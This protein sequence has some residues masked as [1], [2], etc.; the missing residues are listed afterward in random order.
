M[1]LPPGPPSARDRRRKGLLISVARGTD[2]PSV[3]LF[4]GPRVQRRVSGPVRLSPLQLALVSVVYGHAPASVSRTKVSRL[5][6]ASDD[7][8][9]RHRLRQLLVE[10]RAK[11]DGLIEADGDELRTSSG[12]V[13]DLAHFERALEDETL[14]TAAAIARRGFAPISLSGVDDSYDDW[15][16]QVHAGLLRRLRGRASATWT[17]AIETG[18]WASARDAA[19]ATYSLDPRSSEAIARVIEA[20]GRVGDEEEA[21]RAYALYLESGD[22]SGDRSRSVDEVM[23]RV[24]QALRTPVIKAAPPTSPLIGRQDALASARSLFEH[25]DQGRF[26]VTLITGESGI[27]K[28]RLLRELQ[29]EA[30]FRGLRCLG[31]QAVELEARIPLNP[32][33]D[34]LRGVD[35]VPHLN[36]L[37]APWNAVIGAVL[38]PGTLPEPAGEL[39]PIQERALPRRLLDAFSL[40]L[41]RLAN[42]QPTILFLDDLHWADT[43]TI[44][45]L[46][47]IQ[48]RWAGGPFGVMAT[49]RTDLVR[50]EE[51]VA[52]YLFQTDDLLTSRV[53]LR[54][55]SMDEGIQLVRQL[56][57]G[58][59]DDEQCRRICALAGLHP[60]CIAELTRDFVTGHFALTSDAMDELLIPVSLEQIV[61]ERLEQLD[62]VARRVAGFLA[63]GARPMRLQTLAALAAISLE[64]AADA[65]D[66]LRRARLVESEHGRSRVVHELFRSAIYRDLGE[67]RRTLHH[68]AFADQVQAEGEESAGELAIHYDR[69]GARESAARYGWIAADRAMETGTV[70]EAGHFYQLVSDNE[71]DPVRRAEALSGQARALHLARDITRAN[72]MLELAA[73]QLRAVGKAAE[74]LRLDIKRIEGLAETGA[75][76]LI[77]L[78]DRLAELKRHASDH[79]DWEA[80]ALGLDVELHLLHRAGDVVGIR[81]VFDEMRA[82]ADKGC[83]QATILAHAGLAMGVLFADPTDALASAQLAAELSAASGHHRLK[84]L[85]R[86]MVVLQYRGTLQ[87]PE[88]EAII[89]EARS[90]AERSGDVLLRFSIESNVGVACLDAGD[91]ERAEGLMARA[92]AIPGAAKMD[93]NRSIEANNRAELALAQGDYRLAVEAY[94]EAANYFGPT[95]PS[96][97][98]DLVTAGLGLCALERGDLTEARR[99]E[100]DLPETPTRWHFD[101]TTIVA[102]RSRL[103]DRRGQH[104]HA[105]LLLESTAKDLSGRLVLA[106]LRVRAVQVRLMIKRNIP[107]V[108]EVLVEAKTQAE[109]LGLPHRAAEFS[110][111]LA[112][113]QRTARKR[114]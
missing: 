9:A 89:S 18:D 14:A 62:S 84:A 68:K 45:A 85:S 20:R 49:I 55:L 40:L 96:Y 17:R 7:A 58:E 47:F 42:E 64:D 66:V 38:P 26:A 53:E 1:G 105:L 54:E 109:L 113:S 15:R 10:I 51:A 52:K 103:L 32:L 73:S 65:I 46:Q 61:R 12:V 93:L 63:V 23:R 35:L 94:G 81:R 3:D 107:G 50:R 27:G 87:Q 21:E 75:I 86:L 82:V 74:A 102:F 37:G 69:A 11:C 6:W 8:G 13:C 95:T 60:L 83:V 114:Q 90:L 5:L 100:Q 57:N 88:S 48:R 56:A 44:T 25:V 79:S 31:A 24:R 80:V 43:T 76:P 30:S 104:E 29:R 97:M 112:A 106:W 39:P 91:L 4:G 70:A 92:M 110:E 34:A 67:A 16:A 77:A 36:A 59:A 101:P 98:R 108:A 2:A 41:Q 99:R 78:T 33:L 71:R 72:P 19:E 22:P 111:L 28:T